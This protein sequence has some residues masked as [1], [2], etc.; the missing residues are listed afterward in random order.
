MTDSHTTEKIK[1]LDECVPGWREMKHANG[2]RKFSD[3][4][5]LLTDEGKRSVFD[6]VDE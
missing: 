5:T 3:N 2:A 1:R 6:D 4:G